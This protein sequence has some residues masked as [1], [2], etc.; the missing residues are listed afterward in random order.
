MRLRRARMVSGDTPA[1]A[2]ESLQ[3]KPWAMRS[4]SFSTSVGYR[5]GW[6]VVVSVKVIGVSAV[7]PDGHH[8]RR[9]VHEVERHVASFPGVEVIDV[10]TG[11]HGPED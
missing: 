8:L 10:T 6:P 11:Y 5:R 1:A 4:T 2:A 3:A 9:I 7:A